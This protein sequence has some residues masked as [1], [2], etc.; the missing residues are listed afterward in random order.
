VFESLPLWLQNLLG[1]I[2]SIGTRFDIE[3]R[4]IM[5][6]RLFEYQQASLKI[7]WVYNILLN[8]PGGLF[9]LCPDMS[10]HDP[11]RKPTIFSTNP[12][13]SAG[14]DATVEEE[15]EEDVDDMVMDDANL[16]DAAVNAI[17]KD[18]KRAPGLAC[19][20]YNFYTWFNRLNNRYK[21]A[22]AAGGAP[23]RVNSA[24]T[25][26]VSKGYKQQAPMMKWA[27]QPDNKL[28]VDAE[29][30]NLREAWACE[31]SDAS[32]EAIRNMNL[33]WVRQ[34]RLKLWAGVPESERALYAPTKEWE[35]TTPLDR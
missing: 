10:P 30:A 24:T 11:K 5:I 19:W 21:A 3:V 23:I 27:S 9:E 17:M 12:P 13:I 2:N 1:G 16:D 18:M 34:A 6:I 29:I 35:I 32:Q 4:M 7:A 8:G 26:W 14:K 28:L 25:K 33:G 20:Y 22:Q 15:E 31:N